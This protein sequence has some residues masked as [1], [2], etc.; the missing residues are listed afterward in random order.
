MPLV[1]TWTDL[2]CGCAVAP[3]AT[4]LWWVCSYRCNVHRPLWDYT[5]LSPVKGEMVGPFFRKQS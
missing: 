2:D 3:D 5:S 4:G 1:F